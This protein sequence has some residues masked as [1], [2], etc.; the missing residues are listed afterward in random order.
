MKIYD[1]S[2]EIFSCPAFPGDPSPKRHVI[3]SMEN[4]SLYNLSA[5]TMCA[6]NAT[7]VDAPLHFIENGLSIDKLDISK[8]VGLAYVASFEGI[9]GAS[10]AEKML[11]SASLAM[12][13]LCKKLLIKGAATV[14]AEA[15]KIFADADLDLVGN[16]SQTVGPE[17]APLEVHKILLEKEIVLLEGVVL[18]DVKVGVYLLSAAPILLEGSEGAPCR[19]ILIEL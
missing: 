11:T 7:H 10:D 13:T 4:G 16:E 9:V 14:S 12:G 5:F 6:H 1:I 18:K 8:F 2:K 3:R 15:A 19:A 17:D